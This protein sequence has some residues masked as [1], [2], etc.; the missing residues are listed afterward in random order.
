MNRCLNAS[1]H[2]KVSTYLPVGKHFPANLIHP[3][4]MTIQ[5]KDP[6]VTSTAINLVKLDALCNSLNA[7]DQNKHLCQFGWCR[8]Y[9]FILGQ[10]LSS[11]YVE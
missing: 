9:P 3:F 8:I 7:L 6:H 5:N 10:V 2:P 1:H 4:G 11:T